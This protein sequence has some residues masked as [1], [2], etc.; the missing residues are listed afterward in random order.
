MFR[1]LRAGVTAVALGFVVTGCS[2]G[3][4]G[5]GDRSDGPP[6]SPS[7]A[8]KQLCRSSLSPAAAQ[9]AEYLT[10]RK[11]FVRDEKYDDPARAASAV[12]ADY[13]PGHVTDS[14]TF[15]DEGRACSVN[16]LDG[17]PQ[18]LTADFSIV[19]RSDMKD[20][21]DRVGGAYR[22]GENVAYSYP[23]V[24]DIYFPCASAK[25]ADSS[26]DH[27]VVKAQLTVNRDFALRPKPKSETGKVQEEN[28]TFLNS[29]AYAVA[30][31]MGCSDT[32]GLRTELSL[33]QVAKVGASGAP[34]S[35][36]G[37]AED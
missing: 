32:G 25:L 31:D 23:T 21:A 18:M 24:A 8:A 29:L 14:A 3:G 11:R 35:A 26:K 30:K 5:G 27:P 17:V 1:A 15:K 10:G 7:I 22:V 20:R 19:D 9:A 34:S 33:R 2:G 36:S 13:A 6:P 12:D 4:G 28:L 37:A 16:P